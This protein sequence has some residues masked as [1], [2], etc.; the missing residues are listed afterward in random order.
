LT[1]G[2][3]DDQ[4]EVYADA[5]YACDY[6]TGRSV[7]GWIVKQNG[8][9]IAWKSKAQTTVAKSTMESE[10]MAMSDAVTE[11]MIY[12]ELRKELGL[13]VDLPVKLYCDNQAAI[14]VAT[15][16]GETKRSKH[17][18]VRYHNIREKVASGLIAVDFVATGDQ[19]AD[20]L[21]KDVPDI[22]LAKLT[23]SVMLSQVRRS[24]EGNRLR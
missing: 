18:N 15:D 7:T 17:I 11:V 4:L 24:F 3:G 21:T 19:E 2:P 16:D 8:V 22:Q 12:V 5:S 20:M 9:A 23:S 6:T 1:Y 13:P 14:R 10:Y